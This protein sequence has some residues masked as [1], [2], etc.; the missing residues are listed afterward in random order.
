[1]AEEKEPSQLERISSKVHDAWVEWTKHIQRRVK[2]VWRERWKKLFVDYDELPEVEKS[3]DRKFAR[4]IQ[5][6]IKSSASDPREIGRLIGIK[7]HEEKYKPS[8][9]RK[10]MKV[11]EEHGSG[12][13][14]PRTNVIFDD[15][16]TRARITLAH[17][18]E[19]P[20]Y[21]DKLKKIEKHSSAYELGYQLAKRAYVWDDD[22][23]DRFTPTEW[24]RLKR[25]GKVRG[26]EARKFSRTRMRE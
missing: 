13:N 14:D 18:K 16:G 11:E 17:L 19:D 23:E 3:K 22:E 5:K 24:A 8:D 4:R 12:S 1:M 6:V 7:W 25:E 21:Y 10:G 2:P 15:P 26:T 9:L 20:K